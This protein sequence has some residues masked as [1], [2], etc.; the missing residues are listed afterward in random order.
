MNLNFKWLIGA[1]VQEVWM[2]LP[3]VQTKQ[4]SDCDTGK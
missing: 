4:G 3:V 2:D 1:Y